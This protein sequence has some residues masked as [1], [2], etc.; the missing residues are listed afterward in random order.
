MQGHE[1]GDV[2]ATKQNTT[3]PYAYFVVEYT[4]HNAYIDPFPGGGVT[5]QFSYVLLYS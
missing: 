2:T 5:K 1:N 4:V 3:E